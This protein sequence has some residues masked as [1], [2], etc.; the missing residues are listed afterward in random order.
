MKDWKNGFSVF[1]F[2]TTARPFIPFVFH[3]L[4]V[5]NLILSEKSS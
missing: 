2:R 1:Y 4:T 5:L 3:A